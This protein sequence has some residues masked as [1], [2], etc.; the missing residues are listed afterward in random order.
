MA[1]ADFNAAWTAFTNAFANE[2]THY[3]TIN[4]DLTQWQLQTTIA[5]LRGWGF[6]LFTELAAWINAHGGSN[7]STIYDSPHSACIWWAAQGG[8]S[9]T[10]DDI[11]NAMLAAQ[12]DQLVQFI[13]IEQAYMAAIWNAPFNADYFAALA[14]GWRQWP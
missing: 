4:Y 5:G 1:F 6:A 10:M 12:G 8:G 13:G 2:K 9:I 7:Y 14:R 11:L 3:S